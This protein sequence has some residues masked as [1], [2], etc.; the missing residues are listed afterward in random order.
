MWN[1]ISLVQDLNSC[2][3]VHFLTTI[4]ITLRATPQ[5]CYLTQII[6]LVIRYQVCYL[7]EAICTQLFFSVAVFLF[8][9][10]FLAFE[11]SPL[12]ECRRG[13][14][15]FWILPDTCGLQPSVRTHFQKALCRTFPV[16]GRRTNKVIWYKVFLSNREQFGH[17]Y[18]LSS[19]PMVISKG[20]RNFMVLCQLFLFENNFLFA[21]NYIGL[22]LSYSVIGPS[23]FPLQSLK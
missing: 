23:G 8:V 22:S 10:Y 20:I 5:V 12:R 4:T 15:Y 7:I 16:V 6:F 2:R 18:L 13:W 21:P 1:A 19:I 3:R 9:V 14:R 11:A 17:S